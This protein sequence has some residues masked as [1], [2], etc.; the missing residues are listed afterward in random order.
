MHSW[1]FKTISF[2]INQKA[3]CFFSFFLFVIKYFNYKPKKNHSKRKF[4]FLP[5]SSQNQS[6]HRNW[7]TL[8]DKPSMTSS[9]PF[10]HKICLLHF[11]STP[12]E[13]DSVTLLSTQD[14]PWLYS[15]T[16]AHVIRPLI[17]ASG[18][19]ILKFPSSQKHF[20]RTVCGACEAPEENDAFS[21]HIKMDFKWEQKNLCT[22]IRLL[23]EFIDSSQAGSMTTA[24]A[25]IS[26]DE[27]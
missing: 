12:K 21:C 5:V 13:L 16:P 19:N 22:A 14:I 20:S 4:S 26:V 3:L 2:W 24:M 23:F 10:I 17:E 8:N 9:A 25:A 18:K 7:S 27:I 1:V 15:T 11:V 6:I